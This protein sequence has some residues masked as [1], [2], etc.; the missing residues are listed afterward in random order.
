MAAQS[1]EG[2]DSESGITGQSHCSKCYGNAGSALTGCT[3]N[4]RSQ[5]H[6]DC[7]H[8][9]LL[10]L[11]HGLQERREGKSVH[12]AGPRDSPVCQL[13]TESLTS[14]ADIRHL[15]VSVT[16]MVSSINTYTNNDR[17]SKNSRH[18]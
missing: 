1:L 14:R 10:G 11:Q 12:R 17:R 15:F 9:H 4:T 13:L 18:K 7:G 5:N 6:P 8:T 2:T 3:A 16:T